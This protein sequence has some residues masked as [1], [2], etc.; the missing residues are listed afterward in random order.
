MPSLT[1]KPSERN[2]P[3]QR[4]SFTFSA[5]P[6]PTTTFYPAQE[7]SSPVAPE[8]SPITPK[9][10]PVLPASIP[11]QNGAQAS[12]PADTNRQ[13]AVTQE[14]AASTA[15]YIPLPPPQ[16]F[17]SEDST[18]AIALRAAISALQFQKKKARQDL[19]SLEATK[20]HALDNPQLFKEQLAA[21]RLNEQRPQFG[22][23]QAILDQADSD[24]ED[25][26][27]AMLGASAETEAERDE[28][29]EAHTSARPAEVPDSQPSQPAT[30][31]SEQH[32][33]P[34]S[35]RPAGFSRI[36]GPQNVVRMP[37][38]NWEKYH[39]LGEPLEQMHEQQRRFPGSNAFGQD[40]GREFAVAAPYSP[41]LD[42]LDGRQGHDVYG[43][44]KDSGAPG[45]AVASPTGTVSEHPMETRRSSKNN[46]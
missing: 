13:P 26:D 24:D 3:L 34:Q 10:Q 12:L 25:D 44:R 20:N 11:S 35:D 42:V 28:E 41:F 8:Y 45:H 5:P 29:G 27:D 39:V 43:S 6:P 21:G 2:S 32:P 33:A 19:R 23:L 17:S 15:Q 36:P 40:G 16:P 18:D 30:S 7:A 37:H 22:G 14:Q 4:D 9:V 1:I 38:I 46:Q 31:F